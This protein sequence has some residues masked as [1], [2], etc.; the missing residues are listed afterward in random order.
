LTPSFQSGLALCAI[1]NRYRPDLI[2]FGA[3]DKNDP[4]NN[5]Q[6]PMLFSSLLEIRANEQ[7]FFTYGAFTT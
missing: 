6:V 1:I 4:Y 3:I 7:T 2:D 5:I